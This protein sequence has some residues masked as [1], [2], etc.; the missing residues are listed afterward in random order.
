MVGRGRTITDDEKHSLRHLSIRD[1]TL[2]VFS[3]YL[4]ARC[5]FFYFSAGESPESLYGGYS[6][7]SHHD[8]TLCHS[9]R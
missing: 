8:S 6:N 5:Y 7:S 9:S 4:R 2:T 3:F 1:V